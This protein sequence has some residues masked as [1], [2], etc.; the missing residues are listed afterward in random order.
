MTIH[1]LPG[2][3]TSLMK[4]NIPDLFVVLLLVVVVVVVLF[5]FLTLPVV[6]ILAS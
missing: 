1:M 6:F 3:H 5:E 4:M 2:N